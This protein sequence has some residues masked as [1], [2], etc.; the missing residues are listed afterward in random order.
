MNPF[1]YVVRAAAQRTW[2]KVILIQ[3]GWAFITFTCM[4]LAA[5]RNC[6]RKVRR[7]D[8]GALNLTHLPAAERNAKNLIKMI[9]ISTSHALFGGVIQRCP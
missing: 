8:G 5:L 4:E 2:Q 7:Y 3:V 9:S 6:E 1:W